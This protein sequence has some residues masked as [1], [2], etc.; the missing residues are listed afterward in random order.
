MTAET[1]KH[2]GQ[3]PYEYIDVVT[4]AAKPEI[5]CCE[6]AQ[7][8]AKYQMLLDITATLGL[9]GQSAQ[10]EPDA[11]ICIYDDG[12]VIDVEYTPLRELAEASQK[13]IPLYRDRARE[14]RE[15]K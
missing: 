13:A 10:A 14:A 4:G 11:W 7:W 2:C 15:A 8:K 5:I 3:H 12:E 9:S 1:C 6:A